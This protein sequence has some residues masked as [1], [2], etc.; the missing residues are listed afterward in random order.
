[1]PLRV[2][3]FPLLL[4]L[5]CTMLHAQDQ[6]N[7]DSL[8]NILPTLKED[9]ARV[10]VL[11]ELAY[12]LLHENPDSSLAYSTKALE[13]AK[14]LDYKKGMG[15]AYN[16]M[17]TY[18]STTANFPKAL[19][20]L[21]QALKIYEGMSDKRHLVT[22]CTDMGNVFFSQG[23]I[24]ES[25]EY[26]KRALALSQ[27]TGFKVGVTHAIHNIAGCFYMEK[28][29]DS[30]FA[31]MKKY[32][33]LSRELG[34]Q[35]D[36]I[37][38]MANI[39]GL[40]A[41]LNNM[42]LAM[43]YMDSSLHFCI[44]ERNLTQVCRILSDEASI[45]SGTG[46]NEK[47]VKL[48]LMAIDTA[49]K[50]K[51][52]ATR[53]EIYKSLSATYADMKSFDR[54]YDF[55]LRGYLLKDSIF[56]SDIN[57]QIAEMKTKYE[58][59]KKDKEIIKKNAEIKASDMQRN[60]VLIG[61]LLV[62]L[63]AV[64]ILRGYFQKKKANALLAEQKAIIEEKNKDI[65][66][67]MIYARKIQEATLPDVRGLKE[68]FRRSFILFRPRDIVSGDFYWYMEKNDE[69][70]LAAADCTGHGVPGAL[71]SMISYASLSQAVS[72]LKE[73]SP[74]NIL[75]A[76]NEQMVNALKQ[77]NK[78]GESRDGLD[79]SLVSISRNTL[80][81]RHAGA[82]RPVYIIRN[83]EII[84]LKGN[85][86]SIGGYV[87]EEKVFGE[88]EFKLQN[89]DTVY[90]FSDGYSDQFGGGKGKKLMTKHFKEMLLSIQDQP[91]DEHGK[92]MEQKLD[93]W[94][95]A[96][97]QVDDILVIGIRV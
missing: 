45:Y 8:E 3:I 43:Q 79:I 17:G 34:R 74:K 63:L 92:I 37:E 75:T 83:K 66:D 46:E 32:I 81:L 86:F 20:S 78:G 69:L 94:K 4:L 39:G 9:T 85:K 25:Y 56:N 28:K 90:L 64:F 31:Y 27:E 36:V 89:G 70:M 53:Q 93:E 14:K 57:K 6:K 60:G 77:K 21:V 91:I 11:A 30:C 22:V 52:N 18:Y 40:Y 16:Q 96:Y 41:S 49:F 19:E 48:Y 54:A 12:E 55:L 84:E 26:Y 51:D 88:N 71:M 47:A 87:D 42:D 15:L 68:I 97:E 72:E 23:N 82:N 13:L 73:L 50:V 59:E 24:P 33:A 76:L 7:I 44:R 61:L 35:A 95:G 10:N 58:S 5:L 29:Y 38:A 67:S 1:M 65:T 80:M 2:K 62:A